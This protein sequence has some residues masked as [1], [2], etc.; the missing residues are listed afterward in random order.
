M[1]K[2]AFVA[3]LLAGGLTGIETVAADPVTQLGFAIDSSGSIGQDDFDLQ[4]NGIASA[5]ENNV[6]TDGSVEV[7]AFTFANG[8]N[9]VVP[10]TVISNSTTL[11][12]VADDIRAANYTFGG[13]DMSTGISAVSSA[14]QGST[15]FNQ[16]DTF[17]NIS[18]DGQPD[19]DSATSSAASTAQSDGLTGISAEAVG[20]FTDNDFLADNVVFPNSPGP[21]LDT[22]A[23][24][25][26]PNPGSQ[27]F[28][29]VADNFSEF[30]D[31]VDQKVQQ[32]VDPDPVPVPSTF[33]LLVA[34]LFGIGFLGRGRTF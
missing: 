4:T 33:G 23:G 9:E 29:A 34:G 18:T 30:G 13:T 6:P 8:T 24:D 19:S 12:D 21:I 7:T 26:L 15:A 14:L 1:L 31:V 17:I 2:R 32:T 25:T 16:A 27:G 10:P 28:V 22:S 5:L 3:T 11:T 20:S